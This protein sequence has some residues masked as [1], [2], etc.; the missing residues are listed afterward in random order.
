MKISITTL[1]HMGWIIE[2]NNT[3]Y[4]DGH[5]EGSVY[6][7]ADEWNPKSYAYTDQR[8]GSGIIELHDKGG[9]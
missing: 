7:P 4:C 8:D 3:V 1:K 9:G 5:E 2:A 6:L